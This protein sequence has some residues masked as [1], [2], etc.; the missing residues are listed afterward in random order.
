MAGPWAARAEPGDVLVFQGP[1]GGYRPDPEADVHLLVGDESALPAIA[2]S[3]E[4]L[5]AAGR[6]P[7]SGCCA[8]VPTTSSPWSP[9]PTS[10]SSG[11]TARPARTCSTRSP[12]RLPDAGEGRVHAFVHGE[13]V[14]VRALRAHLLGEAG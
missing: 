7:W 9:R 13:A 4:V 8:T 11:A 1:G 2:A 6:G 14:E 12:G 5:P 3:L 10:T